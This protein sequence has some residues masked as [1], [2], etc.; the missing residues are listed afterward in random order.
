M[1]K[2]LKI[3]YLLK[4][5]VHC[6]LPHFLNQ[7]SEN[8]HREYEHGEYEKQAQSI[9]SDVLKTGLGTSSKK[10]G[11]S[12]GSSGSSGSNMAGIPSGLAALGL[13]ESATKQ[14][15]GELLLVA[16]GLQMGMVLYKI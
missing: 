3:F 6:Q 4:Y 7:D 13:S 1:T 8:V 10:E 16:K 14:L 2:I 12:G 9:L 15:K 11:S 5:K